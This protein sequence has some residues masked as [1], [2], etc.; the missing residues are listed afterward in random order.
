MGSRGVGGSKFD[1]IALEVV[2][3]F[4]LRENFHIGVYH[5]RHRDAVEA[6]DVFVRSFGLRCWTRLQNIILGNHKLLGSLGSNAR[7]YLLLSTM[8]YVVVER[9]KEFLAVFQPLGLI[10]TLAFLW[11]DVKFRRGFVDVRIYFFVVFEVLATNLLFE[12]L[13]HDGS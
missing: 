2:K 13:D 4:C 3:E 6:I 9:F 7:L 11:I 5:R 10:E 1:A 12:T 8:G